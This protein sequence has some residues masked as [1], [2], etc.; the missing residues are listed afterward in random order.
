MYKKGEKFLK[1]N[2]PF[3]K[4]ILLINGEEGLKNIGLENNLYDPGMEGF[5]SDDV[6]D[7]FKDCGEDTY[8]TLVGKVE[9]LAINTRITEDIK[10]ELCLFMAAMLVRTPHFK[11]QIEDIDSNLSK[12]HT[13]KRFE[14]MSAGEI[15]GLAK[16]EAGEEISLEQAEKI[17]KN[18]V[19]K[20]Y[21]LKYP[22]GYFLKTALTELEPIAEIL[23][24]MNLTILKS[25]SRYFV[26]SDNPVVY[27]VPKEKVDFYNSPKSLLSPHTEVF[28]SLTKN[29]G[30]TLNRRKECEER[31]TSSTRQMVDI[32]NYNLTHN[33][34]NFI[35]SPLEMKSLEK[36]VKEYIPYP[37]NF[38]IN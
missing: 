7:I 27:F 30:V 13:S 9:S 35:F 18:I 31:I 33:S 6:E 37:F 15:V 21:N 29:L 12:H 3:E 23:R 17:K 8:N 5:S 10:D 28:F 36:F 34:F 4:R 11:S 14:L 20:R 19:E 2:S 26:T 24:R 16:K 25:D 1:E 32:F 38:K 22:N